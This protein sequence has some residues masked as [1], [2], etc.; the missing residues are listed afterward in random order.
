MDAIVG[1][2]WFGW[3]GLTRL[4]G[5]RAGAR[6][7][8]SDCKTHLSYLKQG[9]N[10]ARCQITQSVIAVAQSQALLGQG[11]RAEAMK[12]ANDGRTW[13]EM[14]VRQLMACLKG[15]DTIEDTAKHLCRSGTINDVQRKA[16]Q[17]GL[18]YTS[19]RR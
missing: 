14:D 16:Q 5:T 13:T 12:D 17:L 3:S 18:K 7:H 6:D 2:R 11:G 8:P 15:G 4:N 9:L 19:R 10:D 1:W